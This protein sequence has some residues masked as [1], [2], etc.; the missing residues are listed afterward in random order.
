MPVY[1]IET[2]AISNHTKELNVMRKVSGKRVTIDN[3]RV[4]YSTYTNWLYKNTN[5]EIDLRDIKAML[6]KEKQ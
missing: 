3:P 1:E 6:P 2:K 4:T 5:G